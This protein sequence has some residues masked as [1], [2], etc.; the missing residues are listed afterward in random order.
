MRSAGA[1]SPLEGETAAKQ[2][3][4]VGADARDVD[5][6][7]RAAEATPPQAFGRTLPSRGREK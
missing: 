1:F 4:W 7:R 2:P 5:L 3:E 6:G